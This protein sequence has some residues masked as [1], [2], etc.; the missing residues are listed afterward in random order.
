MEEK[1]EF[2]IIQ[3]RSG[4]PSERSAK[5]S[6]SS[7]EMLTTLTPLVSGGHA[8]SEQRAIGPTE[9]ASMPIIHG[10]DPTFSVALPQSNSDD[11]DRK[12]FDFEVA[13]RPISGNLIRQLFSSR[14]S[15]S[16]SVLAQGSPIR[17]LRQ[18]M[19]LFVTPV[20]QV[21]QVAEK[22]KVASTAT[23]PNSIPDSYTQ[24]CSTVTG[25]SSKVI[26]NIA[27]PMFDQ[28]TANGTNA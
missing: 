13:D 5:E 7:S 17:W 22:R 16:D 9:R 1:Q 27:A 15:Y 8:A 28:N 21:S 26:S 25:S 4:S 14:S 20:S 2:I 3:Q 12:Q 24:L 19:S 11:A 18:S 6:T 23:K 10:S